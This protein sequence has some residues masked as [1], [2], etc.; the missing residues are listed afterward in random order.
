VAVGRAERLT[1]WDRA[2]EL[3]RL[4]MWPTFAAHTL[5]RH[6]GEFGDLELAHLTAP[7]MDLAA[8]GVEDAT[9]G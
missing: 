5:R 7:Q 2:R 4:P 1:G 8:H 3:R 6:S 9:H